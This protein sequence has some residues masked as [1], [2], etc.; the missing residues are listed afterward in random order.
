MPPRKRS[1]AASKPRSSWKERLTEQQ[2]DRKRASDRQLV[3]ES[4]VRSRQTIATLEERLAMLVDEQPDKLVQELL[5]TNGQLE[6]ERDSLRQRLLAVCGALGLSREHGTELVDSGSTYGSLSEQ[7]NN[8]SSVGQLRLRDRP[9]QSDSD[10]ADGGSTADVPRATNPPHN[11]ESQHNELDLVKELDARMFGSGFPSPYPEIFAAMGSADDCLLDKDVFIEAVIQWRIQGVHSACEPLELASRLLHVHRR[12]V[13]LTKERLNHLTSTPGIMQ[14]LVDDL[15][16]IRPLAITM[17]NPPPTRQKETTIHRTKREVAICAFLT[18]SPWHYPSRSSRLAMFWAIYRILMVLVFPTPKHLAACPSWYW[19]VPSQMLKP[20]PSFIDF[21]PWPGV[22]DLLVDRWKD[23]QDRNLYSSFVHNIRICPPAGPSAES[24]IR[25]GANGAELELHADAEAWFHDLDCLRTNPWFLTEFP[26]FAPYVLSDD[27]SVGPE[28]HMH[29]HGTAATESPSEASIR[30]ANLA[31]V[32]ERMTID[33][34]LITAALQSPMFNLYNCGQD[35]IEPLLTPP[36]L[37]LNAPPEAADPGFS[38]ATAGAGTIH[39]LPM[40]NMTEQ[41]PVIVDA[42]HHDTL[43]EYPELYADLDELTQSLLDSCS[44][45]RRRT[46][47]QLDS[48]LL[49]SSTSVSRDA[50]DLVSWPAAM[51]A[52]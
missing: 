36:D 17:N 46:S 32:S 34:D 48:S 8:S 7:N 50:G 27:I 19:P 20:H 4:R 15:S 9:H 41:E 16:G 38:D 37:S 42:G 39:V 22:R 5:Q 23:Y 25:V 6:Q 35:S 33:D 47:Y 21:I 18:I 40:P 10:S 44:A 51:F 26:E 43:A 29:G 49:S 14:M 31:P 30:A 28:I 2:L 24:L 1:D 52:L 3:R 12:P 45:K 13:C 11:T